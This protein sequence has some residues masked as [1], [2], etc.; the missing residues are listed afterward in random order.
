MKLTLS[1]AQMEVASGRPEE[2]LFTAETLVAEAA[3][4]GSGLLCFPEMWTTGF[5][6]DV[7]GQRSAGHAETINRVALMAKRYR[8]WING[9]MPALDRA[10]KTANTSV[11]ISPAGEVT[12]LYRKIHLF[13]Q[14]G[15]SSHLVPG[16]SLVLADTPWGPAGLAVCYDIR[17][18]ELFRSYALRGAC[19]AICPSAFPHPRLEHWRVLIRARAIENQMFFIAVNR[20]GT[21]DLGP[22]GMV[23]YC[24]HSTLVDPWGDTVIEA[25]EEAA[26]LTAEIDLGLVA[27]VRSGMQVFRDRRPDLYGQP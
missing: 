12:A 23:N 27:E 19:L 16:D 22:D 6:W 26:L 17:F 18:P 24:G 4:R 13:S 3:A 5:H 15:E 1:L 7:I 10:G 8:V 11:L 9:S 14:M 20:S 21:E 2:N 25:G